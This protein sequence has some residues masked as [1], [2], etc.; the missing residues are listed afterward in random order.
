[1]R[2]VDFNVNVG[3]VHALLG[4]NGAGKSTLL[5]ILS[6]AQRSNSGEIRLSGAVVTFDA[7]HAAQRLGIATIYQELTL[8]P[9]MS[10]AENIYLGREPSKVS[11]V[12]WREMVA[13]SRALMKRVGLERDPMVPVRD[14]SIAEQQLVEIARALSMSSRLIVMDEPTAALSAAEVQKLFEIVTTLKAEGLSVIF[15]THRLEEVMRICDRYTVLRDGRFVGDGNVK[16]TSIASIIRKMVGREIDTISAGKA[17]SAWER[18][19]SVS[20][21]FQGSGP[22]AA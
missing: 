22:H 9:G 21:T 6:D 8:V 7:P 10:I 11:W 20:T 15:V 3:E 1:M 16:E 19:S 5:K 17:R 18:R 4:E 12:N 13:R 14:L 2:S